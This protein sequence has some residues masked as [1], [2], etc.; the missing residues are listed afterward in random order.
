MS[1][2]RIV[3]SSSQ[4]PANSHDLIRVQGARENNLKD[5]AARSTLTG[6]HLATFV[7]SRPKAVSLGVPDPR[8]SRLQR[9]SH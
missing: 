7:G 4:H 2:S 3:A 5:V 6:E 9:S 8:R 1:R